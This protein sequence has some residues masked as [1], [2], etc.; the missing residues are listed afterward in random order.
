VRQSA[1]RATEL[2]QVVLVDEHDRAIGV[3]E[4]Q[5]AHVNGV[6]HRAISIFV[7]DRAGD[8]MLLQ[9]RALAKY[10]SGGLWSNTCCTHPAPGEDTEDAAHR[11]LGEELGFD[12]PLDFAFRF[13]YRADVG[14]ALTEHEL[15]HVFVARCDA[16][17]EPNAAEVES[18]KWMAVS[19]VVADVNSNPEQ[20]T[21]WFAVALRAM[22]ERGLV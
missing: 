7:F 17:P 18:V 6:L 11:R 3:S 16:V 5:L 12:C 19:D 20:Y 1:A 4:K 8:R 22:R 15:D 13:I 2:A 21:V 9:Q 14:G 10:H